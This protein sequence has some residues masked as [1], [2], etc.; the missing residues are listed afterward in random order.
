MSTGGGAGGTHHDT[1]AETHNLAPHGARHHVPV[2]DGQERDRDE[3]QCVR[4]VPGGIHCLPTGSGVVS[5][6]SPTVPVGQAAPGSWCPA[7]R[8]TRASCSATL[9]S[10]PW[11]HSQVCASPAPGSLWS[12][13]C[14]LCQLP[15]S[16]L[17]GDGDGSTGGRVAFAISSIS[18]S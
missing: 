5:V 18:L 17:G 3:P 1:R 14:S 11:G 2:A 7:H 4:Q 12:Q 13:P 9:D 15:L 8:G 16:P 6:Q 10:M